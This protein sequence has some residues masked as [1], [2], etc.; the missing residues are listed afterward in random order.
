M[1][2]ESQMHQE[3]QEFNQKH[4]KVDDTYAGI[5]EKYKL[6]KIIPW[7]KFVETPSFIQFVGKLENQNVIDLACGE[8]FYTRHFRAQTSGKVYGVDF[9]EKMIELAQYQ[10]LDDQQIVYLQ[11][12]CG[13]PVDV[14]RQFDLV[15]PTFLL[16]NASN[17]ERFE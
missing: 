3:L 6:S 9:S 10:L 7:R 14:G 1:D 15:T 2:L 11:A 16:Q 5:V 12:D 13:L 17:E 4:K 8:G